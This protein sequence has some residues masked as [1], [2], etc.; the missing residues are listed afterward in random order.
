M[1]TRT[2]RTETILR[3][4]VCLYPSPLGGGVR[5]VIRRARR[6]LLPRRRPSPSLRAHL[7]REPRAFGICLAQFRPRIILRPTSFQHFLLFKREHR[8]QLVH[9]LLQLL[10]L[11]FSDHVRGVRRA[12]RRHMRHGYTAT[13]AATAVVPTR[14]PT[15]ARARARAARPAFTLQMF[16]FSLHHIQPRTQHAQSRIAFDELLLQRV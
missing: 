9:L 11:C 6:S 4:A 5:T 16:V 14:R 3:G 12:R 2:E 13:A 15:A 10:H 1:H 8:T 7:R